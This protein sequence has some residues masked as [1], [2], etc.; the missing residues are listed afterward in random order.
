M[1]WGA[2]LW[3]KLGFGNV[4]VSNTDRLPVCTGYRPS[5]PLVATFAA[6]GTVSDVLT[7]PDGYRIEMIEVPAAWVTADMNVLTSGDGTTYQLCKEYGT[8]LKMT[9]IASGNTCLGP[10][11][12]LRISKRFMKLQSGLEGATVVQTAGCAIK[13]WLVS[14]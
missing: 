2:M 9:P 11:T 12:S 7:I 6:G 1:S 10:E 8:N 3:A 4:P 5:T 13:I 14:M